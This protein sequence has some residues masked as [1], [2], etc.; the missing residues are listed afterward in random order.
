MENNIPN[1]VLPDPRPQVEKD[2]DHLH[3]ERYGGLPVQWVEKPQSTWNLPSQRNQNGSFS[4]VMQSS[5]SAIEVILKKVISASV[6]QLRADPTQEGMFSQNAA[7]ILYNQGTVLEAEAPSQNMTDAAI[8]GEKLPPLYIKITGYRTFATRD[9]ESIAEAVQAYGNCTIAFQSNG[10][11]WQITPVYL[12]TPV[13]FGHQIVAVDYTLVNGIQY[14]ICRDSSG[15]FSSPT[16]Y[17][18]ISADFLNKRST[19]A[20]YY[21]GA[22]I[23]P[24][25][26][27]S[28]SPTVPPVAPF[29]VDMSYWHTSGEIKR[30]QGVLATLGYFSSLQTGYYGSY[31]QAAVFQFQLDNVQLIWLERYIYKGKYFGQKSRTAINSLINK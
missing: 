12:G 19:S 3:E 5:A 2:Q 13:T 4:C 21:L 11:E 17:R 7:D 31:T 28:P 9:I 23:T 16:G 8:D 26:T 10:D 24:V 6:Y 15:Q 22:K 20:I 14:L 29:V 27:P 30:L 18:L 25:I 1:A